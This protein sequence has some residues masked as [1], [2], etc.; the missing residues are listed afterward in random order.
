MLKQLVDAKFDLAFSHMY[1]YC[2]IGLIHYAQIP[3]WVWL[4][5]G[6]LID[7]QA[8]DLGLSSPPSYVPR[9]LV[10]YGLLFKGSV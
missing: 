1:E 3:T 6:T 2:S 9:K 7:I 8:H 5:S 4:S 10:L